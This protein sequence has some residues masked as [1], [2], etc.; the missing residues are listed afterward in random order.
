MPEIQVLRE[1]SEICQKEPNERIPKDPNW[2]NMNKQISN[3][4]TG[5]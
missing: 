5:Y 4:Y 3:G 1:G 2:N